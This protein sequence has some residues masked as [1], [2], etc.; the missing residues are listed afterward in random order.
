[1]NLSDREEMKEDA[2]KWIRRAGL[3][4]VLRAPTGED[5]IALTR[6][7][8]A[9][10]VD[11]IEVTTTVPDAADCLRRLRQEFGDTLL[12][13]AGTVT[14]AHAC[15][16]LIEAGAE[17]IVSPSLHP[18][19]IAV[20]KEHGKLM[21][22]GALTPTEI[23]T[24]WRAGAD[25]VKVFPCSAMG[26]ASYLRAIR[27]PFPQIPLI[28][29]GGVTLATAREFLEAGAIALGVGSDLVDLQAI[30]S[31]S[32]GRITEIARAYLAI[33]AEWSSRQA[34]SS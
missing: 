26:G 13:G 22:S 25:V 32:P 2:G 9:G 18:E 29:T 20:A 4:P 17:F 1:M 11:V 23:I 6:A 14:D 8:H 16:E 5:A 7:M 31:G 3:V 24:A 30:R 19:V 10:G 21:V 15:A 34:K 27:A 33:F 28:P 12:L